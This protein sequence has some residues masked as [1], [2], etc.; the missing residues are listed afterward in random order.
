MIRWNWA[1]LTAASLILYAQ[2]VNPNERS[3]LNL[4]ERDKDM[5]IK[6]GFLLGWALLLASAL[7]AQAPTMGP[8]VAPAPMTEKEVITELKKDGADQLLKDLQRRGV[9][10]EMDADTEKRL[11]KAKATDDVI[12]AVTAAGPKERAAAAQAAVIASG[13]IVLPPDELAEFNAL[14]SELDPDKAIGLAEA[15]AQKHPKS[16]ALGNVYAYEANAYQQKGDVAKIVEFAE[17]SVAVDPHNVM[18]LGQLA[19]AIP[20]PQ[21]LKLH[22][23]DEEQE[24]NR[25]EKY[26]QEATQAINDLKKPP[27]MPD[28]DFANRKAAYMA[29][30][31]ADLGMIHLDR[32]QLGLMGLDQDELAKAEKEYRL[33]VSSTDHPDPAAYFR[34]GEACR[35]QGKWDEAIAAFTKASELGK[36]ALKQLA[37]QEIEVVKK[38]KAAPPAPKP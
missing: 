22:S 37:D 29:D 9:N 1:G 15:F 34:L 21:Y 26:A 11:R 28:A 6:S 23:S 17:K 24:L 7:F 3:E 14:Q 36:G 2:H 10:F 32:A 8:S 5:K 25:A 20:T 12:K 35:L 19:F 30:I 18:S 31:H 16:A 4:G 33:A 27:N 38:A 13:G